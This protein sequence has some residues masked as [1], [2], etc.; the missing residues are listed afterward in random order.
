MYSRLPEEVPLQRRFVMCPGFTKSSAQGWSSLF[1][2][3]SPSGLETALCM[4]L[5]KG[6]VECNFGAGGRVVV[7]A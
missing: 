2:P 3:T 1:G 6:L 4:V 7:G 5:E